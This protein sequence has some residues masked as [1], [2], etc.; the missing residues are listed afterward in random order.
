MGDVDGSVAMADKHLAPRH[1]I[2]AI[3]GAQ[4]VDLPDPE[5][6]QDQIARLDGKSDAGRA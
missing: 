5:S 4:I 1:F 3:D 6:P 2:E